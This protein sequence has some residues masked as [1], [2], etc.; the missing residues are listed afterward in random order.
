MLIKCLK[1]LVNWFLSTGNVVIVF[2]T[3][4][5]AD[6]VLN[7]NKE[8]NKLKKEVLKYVNYKASRAAHKRILKKTCNSV[9]SLRDS[10]KYTRVQNYRLL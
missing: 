5:P 10:V 6:V 2:V 7:D 1:S 3:D 8:S 4:Q 9:Q